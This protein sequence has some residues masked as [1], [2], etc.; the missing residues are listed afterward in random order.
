MIPLAF[1][2]FRTNFLTGLALPL[3]VLTSGLAEDYVP[4]APWPESA[5]NP[6]EEQGKPLWMVASLWPDDPEDSSAYQP[7]VWKSDYWSPSSSEQIQSNWPRIDGKESGLLL[8]TAGPWESHEFRKIP[9]LVFVAPKSASYSL[10]GQVRVKLFQG[11]NDV[12]L[13]VVKRANGAITVFEE[14]AVSGHGPI[15]LP[16]APIELAEG[17]EVGIVPIQTKSNTA[18]D[19][20]LVDFRITDEGP[21][22]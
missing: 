12:T 5:G 7:M 8:V 3:L 9:A 20:R 18:A 22:D 6:Y 14:I 2:A 19:V 4:P 16:T 11:E 1:S 21:A 17:E 10:R 13:L 15:D